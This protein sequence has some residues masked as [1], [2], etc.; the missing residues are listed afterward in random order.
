MGEPLWCVQALF[1][2]LS[3]THTLNLQVPLEEFVGLRGPARVMVENALTAL[4]S[5]SLC[6]AVIALVP[7]VLCFFLLL[8]SLGLSDTKVYEP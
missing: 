7:M 3:L 6:I 5:N 4:L 8:S 1:R 2:V